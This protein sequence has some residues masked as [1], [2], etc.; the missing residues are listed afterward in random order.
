MKLKHKQ[1]KQIISILT[2]AIPILSIIVIYFGLQIILA[3]TTPFVAVVSASMNPSLGIGD[4]LIIQGA[5]PENIQKDDIIVFMPPPEYGSVYTIHR[6]TRIQ[7]LG[8]GT[9]LF[10]TKGDANNNEDPYWISYS[11]VH[12]R[13]IYRIPYIGY[14][15][16]DPTI[17][18]VIIVI[19]I[20][21]ILVWPE[22]RKKFHHKRRT[23]VSIAILQESL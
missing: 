22:K 3:T 4:L 14:I 8:N 2:I 19:T 21:T 20:I 23:H 6:V 5:S 12:G 11:R 1:R 18:I 10:K 13:P 16:L 7:Q 17:L 9:L 15:M